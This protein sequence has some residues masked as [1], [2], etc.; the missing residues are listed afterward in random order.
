MPRTDKLR[1]IDKVWNTPTAMRQG[2]YAFLSGPEH[3]LGSKP[4]LIRI[5]KFPAAVFPAGGLLYPGSSCSRMH[6]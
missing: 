3:F 2:N 5:L 4:N 6:L 1:R